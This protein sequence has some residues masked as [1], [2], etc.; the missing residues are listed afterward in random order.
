MEF[1]TQNTGSS[2]KL[3][4]ETIQQL[5]LL[6]DH[7]NSTN[8]RSGKKPSKEQ[9]RALAQAFSRQS[10]TAE[11]RVESQ[12][13]PC[14]IYGGQRGIATEVSPNTFVFQEPE[15]PNQYSDYVMGWTVR[16]RI[17]AGEIGFSPQ[18]LRD[19]PILLLNW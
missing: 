10:F 17:A 9:S 7:N 3:G 13:S 8:K 16:R 2:V 18:R 19:P 11:A 12:A 1:L 4:T 6:Q 15:W 14:A 5:R